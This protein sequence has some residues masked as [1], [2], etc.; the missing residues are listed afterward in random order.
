MLYSECCA[1]A[2]RLIEYQVYIVRGSILNGLVIL[3]EAFFDKVNETSDDILSLH[4]SYPFSPLY[5]NSV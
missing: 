2:I 5:L 1:D 3:T 4:D